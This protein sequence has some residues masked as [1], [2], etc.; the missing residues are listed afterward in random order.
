MRVVEEMYRDDSHAHKVSRNKGTNVCQQNR[1][2]PYNLTLLHPISHGH[3]EH[4]LGLTLVIQHSKQR[5]RGR[6]LDF[7]HSSNCLHWV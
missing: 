5:T 7:R 4:A 2:G 1:S 3:G 6:T